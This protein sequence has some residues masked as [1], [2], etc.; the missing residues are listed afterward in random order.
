MAHTT[1]HSR[2]LPDTAVD[3]LSKVALCSLR[4]GRIDI[5]MRTLAYDFSFFGVAGI[6]T[7]L[8]HFNSRLAEGKCPYRLAVQAL[9]DQDKQLEVVTI[10]MLMKS[11]SEFRATGK[12]FTFDAPEHQVQH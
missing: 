1:P 11:G 5:E 4:K 3:M 12:P 8:D 6:E 7:M 10:G 2:P 9:C